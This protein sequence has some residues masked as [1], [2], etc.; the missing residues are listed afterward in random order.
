MTSESEDGKHEEEKDALRSPRCLE[1]SPTVMKLNGAGAQQN[2]F[3]KKKAM[4]RG[5]QKREQQRKVPTGD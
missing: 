4:S 2:A 3:G 1:V 5:Q